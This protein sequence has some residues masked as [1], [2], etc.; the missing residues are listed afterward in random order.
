MKVLKQA[1]IALLF[2][3]VWMQT[4]VQPQTNCVPCDAWALYVLPQSVTLYM[5]Q[6]YFSLGNLT[7][8][9]NFNNITDVNNV[10]DGTLLYV[11]FTCDCPTSGTTLS[12]T[13]YYSVVEDDE[14][15]AIASI[16]YSNLTTPEA[17]QSASPNEDSLLPRTQLGDTLS[18]LSKKFGIPQESIRQYN[19]TVSF[20][21]L[22]PFT[23]ILFIPA[24][25]SSGQYPPL[26]TSQGE[27]GNHGTNKGLIIGVVV[28]SVVF[29]FV[30]GLVLGHLWLK[31][32][33]KSY[34]NAASSQLTEDAELETVLKYNNKTTD[35]FLRTDHRVQLTFG[36]LA[37]ATDNFNISRKIGKGGFA[38]VFYGKWQG[39]EV[40]V[41]RMELKE[42]H[43]FFSELRILSNVHHAN[44]VDLLGYCTEGY[45]FL[46]YEYMEM[47]TLND[48]LRAGLSQLPWETRVKIAL[49]AARGV[50]YMHEY[51][52][53]VYIHRD[54]KP[55][56]IL[57]DSNF[58]AKV[59][60]FGL[61]RI[62]D[63]DGAG[64]TNTGAPLG[65]YGY[66]AP[67]YA[68]F[69]KVSV[70]TDVYAFG[71]ILFQ[72][73][74]GEDALDGSSRQLS[75]LFKDI[76]DTA[77]DELLKPLVD[78]KLDD[79]NPFQSVWQMAIL[80]TRCTDKDDDLRP[81]MSEVVMQLMTLE[82]MVVKNNQA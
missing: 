70:K 38:T 74:S 44:L 12:H 15:E 65:T 40:A 8:L 22:Q 78:P 20:D 10:P 30:F 60:D 72:L 59:G 6:K 53:P 64:W 48:H 34:D 28:G 5:V 9:Q 69:G 3:A 16:K 14:F 1:V 7:E 21:P 68:Q 4:Q 31:W 39:K 18:F 82:K 33:V 81:S 58:H 56:N 43:G 75:S 76:I 35:E 80:A 19:P 11:P 23:S 62:V 36:E 27:P 73:I 26:I 25:N 42:T 54:L 37:V 77:D 46:V 13:F 29:V 55:S 32:T 17:I 24:K 61:T 71:V 63:P 51:T 45:L 50:E 41:K 67:E 79:V 47:G 57:L 52:N 66:M 49:D 2:L